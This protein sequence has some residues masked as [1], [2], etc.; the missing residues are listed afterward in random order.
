MYRRFSINSYNVSSSSTNDQRSRQSVNVEFSLY[1]T[2]DTVDAVC[3][4]NIFIK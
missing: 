3:I 4:S 1:A 2:V